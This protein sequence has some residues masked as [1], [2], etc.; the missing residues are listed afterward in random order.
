MAHSNFRIMSVWMAL[1][2]V[3]GVIAAL[4]IKNGVSPSAVDVKEVQSY[5][6]K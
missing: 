4:S 2:E 3:A 5:L 6:E 1:G